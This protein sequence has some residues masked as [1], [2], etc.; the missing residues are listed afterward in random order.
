MKDQTRS[1]G[2]SWWLA[3]A[4]A[5]VFSFLALMELIAWANRDHEVSVSIAQVALCLV[6]MFVAYQIAAW[7]DKR[8]RKRRKQMEEESARAE[9]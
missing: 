2:K 6:W 3:P 4:A 7:S 1:L 5:M 8:M 9:N